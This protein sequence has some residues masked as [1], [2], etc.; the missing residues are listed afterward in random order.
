MTDYPETDWV[1]APNLMDG[2]LTLEL[3]A[4]Q[5]NIEYWMQ[6][7][8][9][10]SLRGQVYGHFPNTPVPDYLMR[11]G[12]LREAV[13]EEYAFRTLVEE[14]GT[15][16]LSYA[17]R[18]A[19]TWAATEFYVTQLFDEARHASAFRQHV[20]DLG[21]HP[22]ELD[23]FFEASVGKQR[24][25]I[26]RP[27]EVFALEVAGGRDDFYVGVIMLTIIVEGVL[28]P[29][30][31]MAERKWRVL[32]PRAAE[33]ARGANI[34]EIRHLCVGSSL[35]REH[36]SRNP[37]ERERLMGW[38]ARGLELWKTLPILE[39]LMR[40]EALFQQGMPQVRDLLAEYELV[41]G[42][43]LLDTTAEERL[44][45]QMQWSATMQ[46]ERLRYMGLLA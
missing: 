6:A 4:E 41:P 37:G 39:V 14:A 5:C 17:I 43:R 18:S 19:P 28:A 9:H 15:R 24:D 33:V 30:S 16:A 20:I 26:I 38:A 32:D 40:R 23:A 2:A 10:G 31:E 13:L 42:R 8:A 34:D 27:L 7:V 11:P 35:L 3:T 12:P 25:Q 46:H 44:Q 1:N 36:L 21:I 22:R 45:I 29:S